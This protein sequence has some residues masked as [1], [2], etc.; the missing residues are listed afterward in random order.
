MAS[1]CYRRMALILKS[2]SYY[3]PTLASGLFGILNNFRLSST[4]RI[5]AV[6]KMNLE[7]SV[8]AVR[9][10]PIQRPYLYPTA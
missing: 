4:H 3:K 10:P 9:E 7:K 5:Y 1:K 2:C 6:E 8:W